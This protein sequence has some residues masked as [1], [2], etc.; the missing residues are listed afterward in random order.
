MR[1]AAIDCGSNSLKC[2]IAEKRGEDFN[3]LKD[4]RFQTRLA[5]ALNTNGFL[6]ATAIE[7]TITILKH[8]QEN[9]FP[10][11]QIEEIRA[12]GTEAIRQAANKQEVVDR[13]FRE[14]GIQLSVINEAQETFLEWKGVLSGLKKP[15]Q[16]ITIFDSGGASTE[17]INGNKGLIH[18]ATCFPVGAVNFTQRYVHSDPISP[19]DF[20]ELVRKIF[21]S[22]P[23]SFMIQDTFIGAGGGVYVCACVASGG[24]INSPEEAEGYEITLSELE[25]QINLYQYTNLEQRKQIPGMQSEYADIMLAAVLIY[26]TLLKAS[27]KEKFV[28]STRGIRYGLVAI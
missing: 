10:A 13:I 23:Q 3:C 2:L 7:K 9:E 6:S 24:K 25:R 5:S 8:L 17:I 20:E 28:V 18:K 22:L 4:L 19:T 14:T 26:W 12:V 16:P 27:G 11:Y 1:I 15:L 21:Q